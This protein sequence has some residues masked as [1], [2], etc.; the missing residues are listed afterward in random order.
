MEYLHCKVLGYTVFFRGYQA[1]P[2]QLVLINLKFDRH[3]IKH[4]LILAL[5]LKY[6]Y[7]Y[8]NRADLN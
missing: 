1:N 4:Y 2:F 3:I 6:P 5:S 8:G 7:M